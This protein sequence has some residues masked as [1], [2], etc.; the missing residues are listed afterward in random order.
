MYVNVAV[1]KETQP[2]ERRVALVPSVAPKL[3]KLG[4]KLHMQT[5]AGDAIK[6]SRRGVS[7][8]RLHRRSKGSGQRRRCGSRGQPPALDVIDA[9][10]AGAILISLHLRRTGAGAGAA[11][12]GQE[13]HLFRHGASAA[14]FAGTVD[15]RAFQPIGSGRLLRGSARRDASGAACCRRLRRRPAR[16][17]RPKCWSWASASPVSRRSRPRIAWE[18][19]SKV[20]MSARKPRSRRCR[21]ARHSSRPAST[22]AARADMRA[23]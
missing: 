15:G 11:A 1:L 18:R 9:M 20:M 6:L 16:S 4:A 22:R 5:G 17:A 13:N 12:A 19:S 3:I 14:H 2:H 23:S 7:G 21:W 10:K 8:C